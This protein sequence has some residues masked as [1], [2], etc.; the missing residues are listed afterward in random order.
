M[1]HSIFGS[2]ISRA[3]RTT[4][5]RSNSVA[6]PQ[7]TPS[8]QTRNTAGS[9]EAEPTNVI[10]LRAQLPEDMR[11]PQSNGEFLE[12]ARSIF[13][14]KIQRSL[15]VMEQQ[16]QPNMPENVSASLAHD[17]STYLSQSNEAIERFTRRQERRFQNYSVIRAD[18]T[19]VG[20]SEGKKELKAQFTEATYAAFLRCNEKLDRLRPP[21]NYQALTRLPPPSYEEALNQH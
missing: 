15:A 6:N 1:L 9:R 4:N 3:T 17:R 21:P 13:N 11:G 8:A 7:P 2:S 12:R 16:T 10:H 20:D 18:L 5:T 19:R 14:E